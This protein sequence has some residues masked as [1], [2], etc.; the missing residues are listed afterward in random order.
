[1]ED[2]WGDRAKRFP[3]VSLPVGGERRILRSRMGS[4]GRRLVDIATAGTGL[5]LLS[6]FALPL[7]VALRLTGEGHVLYFQRRVGQGGKPFRICKLATML[8]DSENM[9]GGKVT[10]RNDPRLTPLGG[11]LRRSK[12]N[13]LPQLWNV[14]VGE[15]TIVGPRPLPKVSLEMYPPDVQK[16]V[17]QSKPGLTGIASLVFRDEEAFVSDC[18]RDPIEF[19]KQVVFPYK[20]KL[21]LWYQQHRSLGTDLKIVF[22]TACLVVAPS[23]DWI[24]GWFKGLPARPDELRGGRD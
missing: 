19:Y 11:L 9:P 7:V 13:E 15:M 1:M 3:D 10:L 22:S 2:D 20:G 4:I 5:L 17:L 23:S 21:E 8:Q 24:L 6:P 18:G 12:L 16:V 14:L